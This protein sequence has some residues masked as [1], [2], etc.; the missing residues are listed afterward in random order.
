MLELY[1]FVE[2]LSLKFTIISIAVRTKSSSGFPAAIQ[3]EKL[4]DVYKESTATTILSNEEK[5]EECGIGC[6]CFPQAKV[7]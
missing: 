1:R 4:K 7:S 3:L 5:V 2:F 6:V